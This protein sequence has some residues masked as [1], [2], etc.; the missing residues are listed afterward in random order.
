MRRWPIASARATELPFSFVAFCATR[1]VFFVDSLL[2][3]VAE[4]GP[5]VTL[6][7]RPCVPPSH[8]CADVFLELCTTP[9]RF[10]KGATPISI[11]ITYFALLRIENHGD[12]AAY[13]FRTFSEKTDMEICYQRQGPEAQDEQHDAVRNLFG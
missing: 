8:P 10:E 13:G 1:M 2:E 12:R 4:W 5:A 6:L 7:V 11:A 9:G 3:T